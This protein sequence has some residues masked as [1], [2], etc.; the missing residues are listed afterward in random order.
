MNCCLCKQPIRLSPK[1]TVQT[2]QFYELLCED[3]A[4]QMIEQEQSLTLSARGLEML[5]AL[6]H[7]ADVDRGA[8][9]RRNIVA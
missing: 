1:R 8:T 4:R 9:Q 6:D 3:H 5:A 2:V 7:N